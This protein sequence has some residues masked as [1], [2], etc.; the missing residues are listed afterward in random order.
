M[1]IHPRS[2]I[3]LAAAIMVFSAPALAIEPATPELP[4]AEPPAQ[5][6]MAVGLAPNADAKKLARPTPVKVLSSRRIGR[7]PGWGHDG[8]LVLGVGF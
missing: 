6:Q 4:T 5:V 7:F 1:T 3:S 2:L 8:F